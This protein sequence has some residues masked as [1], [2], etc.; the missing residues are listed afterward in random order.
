[1]NVYL[2]ADLVCNYNVL[3]FSAQISAEKTP[4]QQLLRRQY[5]FRFRKKPS[6]I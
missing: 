2:R 6:S 3:A 4:A 5:L 1:M